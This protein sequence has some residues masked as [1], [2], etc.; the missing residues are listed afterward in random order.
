MGGG[1]GQQI[2]LDARIL[3]WYIGSPSGGRGRSEP[4]LGRWMLGN[5]LMAAHEAAN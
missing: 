2:G 1:M 4:G 5:A 3:L